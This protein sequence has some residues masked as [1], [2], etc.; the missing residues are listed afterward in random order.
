MHVRHD[1][2][3]AWE[4]TSSTRSMESTAG[5]SPIVPEPELYRSVMAVLPREADNQQPQDCLSKAYIPDEL[6][7]RVYD[8]C[9]RLLIYPHPYC[10]VGLSYTRRIKTERSVPGL[11]YQRMVTAE[12]RLKNEHYPFQERVFVLADPEVFSGSLGQVLSGDIETSASAADGSPS[13]LDHMCLVVQH[14]LQA[15]LG[16]EQCHGPKLARALKVSGHRTERS[17]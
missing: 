13:P 8:F 12:Q 16:A 17:G 5:C 11:M 9:K 7:K 3:A 15:A 2:K 1:Q 14:S 4:N 6:Y 10:T